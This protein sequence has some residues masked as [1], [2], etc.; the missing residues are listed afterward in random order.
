MIDCSR[1]SVICVSITSEFAPGYDVLT[2]IIA[3]STLGN[4]R[5]PRNVNPTI[6]N[7]R[8]TIAN[9]V[10]RTGLFILVD[11]RLIFVV[12]ADYWLIINVS[13]TTGRLS[14]SCRMPEVSRVSPNCSPDVIWI[15]DSVRKPVLTL[16]T[17]ALPFL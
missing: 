15:S 5:I 2:V 17:D 16:T 1:G 11:D 4:S 14:L 12:L 7:R 6:P 8:M 9:T 13:S 10:V 3:G